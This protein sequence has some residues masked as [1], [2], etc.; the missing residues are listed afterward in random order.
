MNKIAAE[1]LSGLDLKPNELHEYI[2]GLFEGEQA[3]RIVT[4]NYDHMLEEAAKSL[5]RDTK[6]YDA[7]ALPLGKDI[8]SLKYVK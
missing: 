3:I 7:P 2:I 5:N 6:M 4:T 8:I 1:K